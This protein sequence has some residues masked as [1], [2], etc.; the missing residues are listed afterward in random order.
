MEGRLPLMRDGLAGPQ[1]TA[2]MIPVDR[3][4]VS[5]RLKLRRWL[6]LPVYA[7]ALTFSYVSEA[8]GNLAA[9]IAQ[10]P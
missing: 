9:I 1:E 10:D 4:H 8:L 2:S 6:A 7:V 5:W 3:K